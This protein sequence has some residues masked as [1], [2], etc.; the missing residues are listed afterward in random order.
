ML[1]ITKLKMDD[2]GRITFP[3]HFLDA[4]DIKINSYVKILPVTNDNSVKIQFSF[5]AI[6]VEE[7]END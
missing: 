7:V 1:A 6:P 5:K 2:R 3:R 4:N